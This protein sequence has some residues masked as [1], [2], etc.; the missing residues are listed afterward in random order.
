MAAGSIPAEQR[1]SRRILIAF[2]L[3]MFTFPVLV[4]GSSAMLSSVFPGWAAR[5]GLGPKGPLIERLADGARYGEAPLALR[6]RPSPDGS[7]VTGTSYPVPSEDEG[8]GKLT[9]ACERERLK[10]ATPEARRAEPTLL[11]V[12]E[13]RGAEVRVF[14]AVTCSPACTLS[15]RVEAKPVPA[16]QA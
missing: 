6:D 12:G 5:T 15:L 9:R 13:D 10:I 2:V 8:L 4:V 1:R 16:G 3:V 14:A 11:C 7:R